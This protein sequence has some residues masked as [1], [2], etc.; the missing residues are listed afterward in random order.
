ME[1]L[2]TPD[3][4]IQLLT[5][6]PED[7][8]RQI[9]NQAEPCEIE[10]ATFM[11]Y[12]EENVVELLV[13][14]NDADGQIKATNLRFAVEP[15]YLWAAF[16]TDYRLKMIQ[17]YGEFTSRMVAEAIDDHIKRIRRATLK[18]SSK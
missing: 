15:A 13:S 5:R 1:E 16:Q 2:T 12:T 3:M 14:F 6:P 8:L 10:G 11:I 18:G 7:R 4:T 17:A 9:F